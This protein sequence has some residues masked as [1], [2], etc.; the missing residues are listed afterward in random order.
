MVLNNMI[1]NAIKYTPV[2][3]A[4]SVRAAREG[5][6]VVVSV[7]DNGIGIA[8]SES[9]RIFTKFFRSPKALSYFTDGSGLGL[10]V[11]KNIIDRHGGKMWFESV[12]GKGTTFKVSLPLA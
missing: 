5:D 1:D 11:S 7:E 4:V 2:G 3:G 8:K 12:E 10:Y 6:S 9:E